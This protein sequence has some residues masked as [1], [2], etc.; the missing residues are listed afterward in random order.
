MSGH[1]ALPVVGHHGT[2]NTALTMS[3]GNVVEQE[4]KPQYRRRLAALVP[5]DVVAFSRLMSLN[6]VGMLRRL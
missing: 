3:G 2:M 5:K 6:D 1:W 4:G